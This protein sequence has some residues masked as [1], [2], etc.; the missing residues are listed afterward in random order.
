MMMGKN[1]LK[2]PAVEK[3]IEVQNVSFTYGCHPVLENVDIAINRGEAVGVT[4]PNG[5]GKTTL[6]NLI[7]GQIKPQRGRVL[8][9]GREA[10]KFR[11][12][13]RIAYIPQKATFINPSFPASV[14]EVVVSGLVAGKGL[15]RLF[16][17]R[18]YQAAED[19]LHMVGLG[20][21]GRRPL[22]S[23]SGGQQQ[24]VFIARALAGR[25]EILIMD[26]PTVGIDSASRQEIN[27]LLKLLNREYNVTLLIV[28][29]DNE[30]LSD[31]INR[32]VC[33]NMHVC[34]CQH[35]NNFTLAPGNCLGFKPSY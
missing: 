30:W 18:D 35:R 1:R 17:S 22:S 31:V 12:K 15:L 3:V 8:L 20:G 33:L 5:A 10:D 2:N 26:E 14:L 28:S 25:P 24:R 29:H 7:M 27:H 23:L 19:A 16:N 9:L 32:K 21:L 13:S 4:G 11:E 34:S 6:L